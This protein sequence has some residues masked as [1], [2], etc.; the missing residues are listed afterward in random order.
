M[1]KQALGWPTTNLGRITQTQFIL[2]YPQ[3]SL[4][5]NELEEIEGG[6][7]SLISCIVGIATAGGWNQ[8][9][10]FLRVITNMGNAVSLNQ[11]KKTVTILGVTL[12]VGVVMALVAAVAVGVYMNRRN[13]SRAQANAEVLAGVGQAFGQAP[14]NASTYTHL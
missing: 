4:V 13:S 7:P 6:V 14:S 10:L 3:R 8:V 1:A 2:N 11:D 9:R 12:T 5:K